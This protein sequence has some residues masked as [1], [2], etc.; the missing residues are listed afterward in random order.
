MIETGVGIQNPL[1]FIGVVENNVDERL[2]GRVQVRAFGV[3][4]TNQQVPTESLPWAT[5]VHGSYDPNAPLPPVNSF[6]FGFFIDGRDAQQ[7]MILGLIPTQMT[8]ILDPEVSG[9]GRI[10]DR[11]S[12]VLSR[13]SNPTDLGEPAN[14][15]LVRGE[16][17]DGTYV[18]QQAMS[19]AEGIPLASANPDD[20]DSRRLFAEPAPAYNTEYP[21]NRVIQTAKHS[22]ELDDTPGGERV[23]IYTSSGSYIAIDSRGTS[24]YKSTSDSYSINDNHHNLYVRGDYN[25]TV[26]GDCRFLVQGNKIEE[27]TGDLIQNVRG[28]HFLSVGGQSTINASEEVQVRGAKLRL[29]ANVEGININ[30]A[31]KIRL[32]SGEMMSFKSAMEMRLDAAENIGVKSGV[33]IAM[34]AEGAIDINAQDGNLNMQSS[35]EVNLRSSTMYINADGALDLKGGHV[36]AGGGSKVSIDASIVAIDNIVQL[37]NGQATTPEGAGD[38]GAAEAAEDAEAVEA[39]EP[40]GKA[41]STT[42]RQPTGGGSLGHSGYLSRD[43]PDGDGASGTSAQGE[44]AP[45]TGRRLT[46]AQVNEILGGE[47]PGQARAAA[48]EF[49]GRPLSDTEWNNLVAATVAESLPNSPEEQAAVMA[50]ILNRVRS[51]RY[52]NTVTEVLLQRNQ[53]QAVTGTRANGNAPSRNFT[54]PDRGQMASTISGVNQYLGTMDQGWLNFTSNIT[55]AYGAGTNIGFRDDVRNATG[56][57]VIGGTVFGTV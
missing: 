47:E 25:I 6:V 52:P 13:G 24:V 44:A 36:K 8:E 57:R 54:N 27:V 28:N 56:S 19:R 26:Q 5:L 20:E 7:P 37:A 18:T 48:E 31:K 10:I 55:A 3:H 11:G 29:Q 12:N 30:A 15:R 41:V 32:L 34:S 50:V 22:I 23:T 17:I 46:D 53:F 49:L 9:W 21:Y 16:D 1:F 51:D 35:D 43:E 40:V 4:G 33:G 39:P 45:Y 14:S 2:E 38:A 42:R